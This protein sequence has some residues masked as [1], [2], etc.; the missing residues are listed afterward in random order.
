MIGILLG[1]SIKI[2]MGMT[3]VESKCQCNQ[4]TKK[5]DQTKKISLHTNGDGKISLYYCFHLNLAFSDS[6]VC[7]VTVEFD[8][9]HLFTSQLEIQR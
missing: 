8:I 6:L 3:W 5:K 1:K 4:L 9:N 7:V 2:Y